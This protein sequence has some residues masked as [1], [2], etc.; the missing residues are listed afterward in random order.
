MFNIDEKITINNITY[1]IIELLG[2]GKGGYSY[3]VKANNKEYVLKKI[4]HEPCS[5]YQFDNKIEAELND[6]NRLYNIGLRIPKLIYCDKEKEIIIKEYIKGDLLADL[7]KNKKDISIYI[8]QMR[9]MLNI[10]YQANLNIDYYPTN[11][12]I[13]QKDN[14]IYYIDYECNLYDPK[15]DF[16]NWGLKYWD[17]REKIN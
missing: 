4:H 3:L 6:Y 2:H 7:I 16:D 13:N 8:K 15:W 14:L 17:G 11:F 9:E 1:Q 10:I 12:I 5:Y